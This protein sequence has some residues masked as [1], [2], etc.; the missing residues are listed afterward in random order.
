MSLVSDR[1][2]CDRS[3]R[4][5]F[6]VGETKEV[7][8]QHIRKPVILE[9]GERIKYIESVVLLRFDNT[10]DIDRKS[11]KPHARINIIFPDIGSRFCQRI[12]VNGFSIASETDVNDPFS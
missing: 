4:L 10:V 9:L 8:D 7:T 5:Q 11:L 6:R 1:Y 3:V 2:I 12:G